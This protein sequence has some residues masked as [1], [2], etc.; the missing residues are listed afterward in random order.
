MVELPVPECLRTTFLEVLHQQAQ[1]CHMVLRQEWRQVTL[2]RR[3]R[4][5]RLQQAC[6]AGQLVRP[7]L[8]EVLHQQ[9]LGQQSHMVRQLR[10]W[11]AQFQEQQAQP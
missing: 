5:L 4:T 9:R 8:L 6:M 10:Q 7:T 2:L 3:Q 11:A 1:S